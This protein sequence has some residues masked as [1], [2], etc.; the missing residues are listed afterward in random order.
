MDNRSEFKK[1]FLEL[2]ENMNL[3]PNCIN[4]WNPQSNAILE[5]IHQ[6]LGDGM[7]TFDLENADINE[8]ENNPFDEYLSSV[9][10]AI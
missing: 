5:Q 10:Y 4:S 7:R 3:T 9:S 1:T 8:D 6:V 2:C